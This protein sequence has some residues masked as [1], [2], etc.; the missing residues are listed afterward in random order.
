MFLTA[1]ILSTYSVA[2]AQN[3]YA[4]ANDTE[5]LATEKSVTGKLPIHKITVGPTV[6]EL[7]RPI[8]LNHWWQDS[9]LCCAPD[10]GFAY[11]GQAETLP[12]AY[13]NWQE[14][15][16][17]DFQKLYRNRPFEMTRTERDRW[18]LLV[19]VIDV[20]WYKQNTPLSVREI[21]YV[22][23]GKRSYPTHIK[24]INGRSDAISLGQAP[25]EL[26]D[27]RPGQWI[28]AIVKRDPVTNRLVTIDH[29]E[30]ISS[31]HMPSSG[32]LRNEWKAVPKA[33]VPHSEWDWPNL[34]QSENEIQQQ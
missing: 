19:T 7:L 18:H 32:T 5:V 24:W 27:C 21:G 1:Q 4:G 6:Y 17:A 3:I 26:A 10:F 33:K 8:Q 20:L 29:V 15:V 31:L 25:P 34:P 16:H 13:V 12:N 28:E 2:M 30:K 23:Y 11:I 14:L 22:S 9:W